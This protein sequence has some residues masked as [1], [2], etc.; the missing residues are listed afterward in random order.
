MSIQKHSDLLRRLG[1]TNTFMRLCSHQIT[2]RVNS[3]PQ[4][5]YQVAGITKLTTR[6]H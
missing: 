6:A 3:L 2:F 4:S 5:N 1:L